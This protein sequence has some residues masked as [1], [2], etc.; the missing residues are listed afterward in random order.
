MTSR[1]AHK[2]P[3][4]AGC[5]LRPDRPPMQFH[6]LGRILDSHDGRHS[7]AGRKRSC[8]F[9]RCAAASPQR[10]R[11][12]SQRLD[13][14]GDTAPAC[15]INPSIAFWLRTRHHI[16]ESAVTGLLDHRQDTSSR[17]LRAEH[18]ATLDADAAPRAHLRQARIDAL[19][20]AAGVLPLHE[21][22]SMGG[23][24]LRGRC[25]VSTRAM[26][27]LASDPVRHRCKVRV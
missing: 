5:R 24:T 13:A 17:P 16:H 21:S 1:R 23:E 20:F 3:S 11:A 26:P 22:Y 15:G 14:A 10:I 4:G 6:G 9:P 19:L 27:D 25:G 8:R 12:S 2:M 7:A 18:K